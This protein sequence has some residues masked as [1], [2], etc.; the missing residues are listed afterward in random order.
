MRLSEFKNAEG[1]CTW[2]EFL[3]VKSLIAISMNW[4]DACVRAI[5]TPLEALLLTLK[6]CGSVVV[7]LYICSFI[8][9]SVLFFRCKMLNDDARALV[10]RYYSVF[11]A[12]IASG[13]LCGA[14]AWGSRMGQRILQ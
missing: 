5:G 9:A 4:I 11:T 8:Q 13:S 2:V 6:L 7:G 12:L 1:E 3:N 14:V 10:W